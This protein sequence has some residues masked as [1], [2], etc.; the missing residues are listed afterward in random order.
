MEALAGARRR[1]LTLCGACC[2]AGTG[3]AGCCGSAMHSRSLLPPL[4]FSRILSGGDILPQQLRVAHPAAALPCLCD[5]AL[6]G[7]YADITTT[8]SSLAQGSCYRRHAALDADLRGD[9]GRGLRT[10]SLSLPQQ[11]ATSPTY[12][13]KRTGAPK[14]RAPGNAFPSSSLLKTGRRR[15]AWP[16]ASL[17][18]LK[19]TL[20]QRTLPS[21]LLPALY[22]LPLVL[23]RRHTVLSYMA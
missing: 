15:R 13:A 14:P 16:W 23:T 9:F 1:L 3:C 17:L 22:H 12:V 5:G 8:A 20:P 6:C 7:L 19:A 11:H 18:G 21:S 2:R 4:I 10:P